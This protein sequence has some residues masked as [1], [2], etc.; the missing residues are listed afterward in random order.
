LTTSG[1]Q[2]EILSFGTPN[3]NSGPDFLNGSIQLSNT[4]WFG[5]IEMHIN[6][7]DWDKHNHT[8]DPAYQNVILHVVLNHDK[9]ILIGDNPIPTLELRSRI[10]PSVYN[11]FNIL[12][13]STRWIPCQSWLQ[14]INDITISSTSDK[15]LAERLTSNSKHILEELSSSDN[16][17]QEIIYQRLFWSFGLNVNAESFLKLSKLLPYKIIQKHRDSNE[18][19]ESLLF[20]T[21]G[22]LEQDIDHDYI[23]TL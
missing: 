8:D 16:D 12:N 2:L 11:A 13:N 10:K 14:S 17:W 21:A 1:D 4:K 7:S 18:I 22:L 6:S 23:T 5:H 3:S 20:G 15:V 19:V 9:T